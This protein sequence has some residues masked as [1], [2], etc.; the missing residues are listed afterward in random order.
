MTQKSTRD[1]QIINASHNY[2]R[3]L[4]KEAAFDYEDMKCAFEEGAM[5]ADEYPKNVW[6]DV[7]QE[8]NKYKYILVEYISNRNG[9]EYFVQYVTKNTYGTLQ[10]FEKFGKCR[11]TYIS[12]ILPK[13]L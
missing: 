4:N 10:E 11:W 3:T 2:G 9:L 7:S 13:Q 6:R 8:P 12:D 5:W 1:R